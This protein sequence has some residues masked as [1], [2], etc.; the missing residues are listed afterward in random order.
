MKPHG[1]DSLPALGP[2][3]VL[4]TGGAGFVGVNLADRL[5]QG[6]RR[7]R[8]FDNLS[9]PGVVRNLDWLR[10]RYP[11]RLE[12]RIADIRDPQAVIEAT[13][14][15][16]AVFHFAAQVAVTTSLE[17]P[18]SDLEINLGGTFHLL[19]ALR[20]A[21]KPPPLVYTSTNK[22]YGNLPGL[23]VRPRGQ[24]YEPCDEA[25]AGGVSERQPLDF[26]SPYGCSKGAA[27]QYVLD[28]ARSYGLP[29]AVVRM[30]CI[31]GHHQCGTEDQGWVAHFLLRALEDR[32]ITLY[33]DGLQ[34]RD[35]LFAEDLMTALLGLANRMDTL[36]G[37]VFNVGGGP[38]NTTSLLELIDLIGELHG[39]RPEVTFAPWRTG[40][41]K[42]YVSDTRK[43]SNA[44]GWKPRYPV[45]EGVRSTYEWL[46]MYAVAQLAYKPARAVLQRQ[47]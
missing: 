19:E 30:S 13:R 21:G 28:Y 43:L 9:R 7:V 27:D 38:D 46:Q 2:G 42:Y 11:D 23:A 6:G 3:P 20:A 24:R 12:V 31:Y 22:V 44:I 1:I 29:T 25:F 17:D 18:R 33:G 37:E 10:S 47:G 40:D 8:L 36:K 16:A 5:L 34:V 39:R 41:Q 35:I 4:I 26:H 32:P 45:R 15:A 14:G